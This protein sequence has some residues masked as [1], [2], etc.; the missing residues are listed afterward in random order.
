MNEMLNLKIELITYGSFSLNF[1]IV[2]KI[3]RTLKKMN[4]FI[5]KLFG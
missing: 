5:N 3:R 1:M 2:D 4:E